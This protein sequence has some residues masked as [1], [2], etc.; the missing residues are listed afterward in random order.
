MQ[1][2]VYDGFGTQTRQLWIQ[3]VE[4]KTVGTII[5]NM[6]AKIPR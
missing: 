3:P 2:S 4:L 5:R 1:V 6:Y